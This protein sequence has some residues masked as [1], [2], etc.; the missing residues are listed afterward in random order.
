LQRK[1][2]D[3]KYDP[4]DPCQQI[5]AVP[6]PVLQKFDFR[7]RPE[8]EAEQ[9]LG[10]LKSENV[11]A[12]L[13][14]LGYNFQSNPDKQRMAMSNIG[15]LEELLEGRNTFAEVNALITEA[16]ERVSNIIVENTK[17]DNEAYTSIGG[18][19]VPV[20]K[21]AAVPFTYQICPKDIYKGY[22][23]DMAL[24]VPDSSWD[25][26]HISYRMTPGNGSSNING[27]YYVKS[28][29]GNTIFLND[30]CMPGLDFDT[31]QN[32]SLWI[33]VSFSNG[34]FANVF[35]NGLH[36][37]ACLS[38]KFLLEVEEG[39]PP[40]EVDDENTFIPSGFGFKQ[41]GIADYLKV[42]QTTH[43]YVEGEVAHIE[44]IMAR[45]YRE[46]STRKLRRSENTTT[47]SS[48]SEREQSFQIQL[49]LPVLKCRMKLPK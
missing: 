35:A 20:A 14:V 44:N 18:I 6:E 40:V 7:F 27:D 25:I 37:R 43:A 33:K 22:T 32:A 23:F 10:K 26:D 5:P 15:E 36:A 21:G 34:N 9:L 3:V 13:D 17:T 31:I 28:R 48:D 45:E 16:A 24:T 42:E 19:L 8:I 39:E 29:S 1:R 12:L 46:K 4:A 47:K 2:A 38:D 30:L 41:I 11:D 49:Q